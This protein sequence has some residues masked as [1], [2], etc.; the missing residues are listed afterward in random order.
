MAR[1]DLLPNN[2]T[3]SIEQYNIDIFFNAPAK[4][5]LSDKDVENCV[6]DI[7]RGK[8]ALIVSYPRLIEHTRGL[9]EHQQ[10]LNKLYYSQ[11]MAVT[12]L[13][14]FVKIFSMRHVKLIADLVE[15]G[16][17]GGLATLEWLNKSTNPIPEALKEKLYAACKK[18]LLHPLAPVRPYF[19]DYI[20]DKYQDYYLHKEARWAVQLNEDHFKAIIQLGLP[21]DAVTA[22]GE[23][24]AQIAFERRDH[25]RRIWLINSE[26]NLKLLL[27]LIKSGANLLVTDKSGETLSSSIQRYIAQQR[28]KLDALIELAT[29]KVDIVT[30]ELFSNQLKGYIQLFSGQDELE[31]L[32]NLF[33]SPDDKQRLF[34]D[35][36]IITYLQ[37]GNFAMAAS[38]EPIYTEMELLFYRAALHEKVEV[39]YREASSG[40][41][42]SSSPRAI[43]D[44]LMKSLENECK[45]LSENGCYSLIIPRDIY[46]LSEMIHS[47]A[48]LDT[49]DY[50]KFSYLFGATPKDG[51]IYFTLTLLNLEKHKPHCTIIFNS[52]TSPAYFNAMKSRLDEPY[53]RMGT[54]EPVVPAPVLDGS[55]NIQVSLD[56]QNCAIYTNKFLQTVFHMVST[57]ADLREAL[58]SLSEDRVIAEQQW[59]DFFPK[60]R[61]DI[62]ANLPEFFQL[63]GEVFVRRPPQA[64]KS[65]MVEK[66]WQIGQQYI[67]E[68]HQKTVEEAIQQRDLLNQIQL[69][70]QEPTARELPAISAPYIPIKIEPVHCESGIEYV[71]TK[72]QDAST[73]TGSVVQGVGAGVAP[74][75]SGFGSAATNTW[76]SF[77]FFRRNNRSDENI[78][79]TGN[80]NLL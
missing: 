73:M 50:G 28:P 41:Y 45:S 75:A 12:L 17:Q 39:P 44:M 22:D 69:H 24:A 68:Q 33:K 36:V 70:F 15:H 26:A 5:M 9:I 79:N 77:T 55:I 23:T 1:S 18:Q 74:I 72:E 43:T 65:W 13:D 35:P 3:L 64:L 2:K 48:L 11:G 80:K 10:D 46:G 51:H 47:R 54:E 34:A 56:D 38:G 21:I 29:T 52:W 27:W 16:A 60:F 31:K 8:E 63:V 32:R 37:R 49:T 53:R 7:L 42:L 14:V 62:Q 4:S 6:E 40:F 19:K 25:Q 61:Q 59:Q 67:S 30:G 57:S 71:G 58:E 20:E 66:R 78:L 76:N